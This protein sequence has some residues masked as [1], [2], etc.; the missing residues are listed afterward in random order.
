MAYFSKDIY[1]RKREYAFQQ[2]NKGIDEI[3]L[4]ILI[5][6]GTKPEDEDFDEKLNDLIEELE[7]IQ[8]LSHERHNFHSSRDLDSSYFD[9]IGNQYNWG[10]D[11]LLSKVNDLNKKYK[12]IEKDLPNYFNIPEV[13]YDVDSIEDICDYYGIE[14]T[15]LTNEIYDKAI[16]MLQEDIRKSKDNASETIRAWFKEINNK[17]GTNFPD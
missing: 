3:A 15:E 2:S 17:Y 9:N 4:E 11:T 10:E 1:D 16:E 5:K 7:P 6:Q 14:Y 13:D 12:I 8:E